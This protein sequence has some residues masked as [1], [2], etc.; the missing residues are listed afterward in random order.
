M[1][2]D[3]SRVLPAL[4]QLL[5]FLLALSWRE[6]ARAWAAAGLGDG[7]A[8]AAGRVS[9]NPLRHF[10][11][12]GTL[13]LPVAL[14]I[15]GAPVF[16]WGRPMPLVEASLRRPADAL[17][18]FAAGPAAN[19]FA[20]LIATLALAV[21]SRLAGGAGTD[22]AGAALQL[23]LFRRLPD[24]LAGSGS[25]DLPAFFVLLQIAYVNGFLAVFHLLPVPPL[26]GGEILLRVMPPDWAARWARLRPWG[27]MIAM[28]LGMLGLV[29]LLAAP[30]LLVLYFAVHL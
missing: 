5:V 2:G 12:F 9:L 4:V 17:R 20:A 13:L 23:S 7:T 19:L 6:S 18:V 27:H 25:S 15:V 26:D 21:A 3:P 24:T 29:S 14:L 30:I 16:G 28:A 11:L 8:R 10:D 1:T 22:A